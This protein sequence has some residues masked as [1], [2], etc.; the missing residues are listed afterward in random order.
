MD[1]INKWKELE[2][3]YK[4][5]LYL[6]EL[7]DITIKKYCKDVE[8]FYIW[9]GE[10]IISKEKVLKYKK[11]LKNRYKIA[12]V[13]SKI[14]SLN[15]FFEWKGLE[16]YKV[17]SFRV[18]TSTSVSNIITKDDYFRL[19]DCAKEGKKWKM[20]Y[21]MR[22]LAMTGIRIGELRY[23]TVESINDCQIEIYNKGKARVIYMGEQVR[24]MLKQ[25][26]MANGITNGFIFR[27]SKDSAI[28]QKTVWKNLKNISSKAGVPQSKVYPHSF[29]HLFA[30][31]YMKVSSDISELADILGHT[32]LETTWRYTRTSYDEKVK[33]LD[34]MEL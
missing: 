12:S 27:G 23:I 4:K 33:M 13:N 31:E 7:S 30:K 26:C 2:L 11:Y 24:K 6:K 1:I 14:N 29:R 17:K 10:N 9:L 15:K 22:T 18:Q 16:E 34:K 5:Y 3:D 25:Y 21:I 20:Y 19:L 8:Q 28:S 32:R